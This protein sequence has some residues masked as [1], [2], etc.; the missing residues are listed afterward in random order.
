MLLLALLSVPAGL[1]RSLDDG[2]DLYGNARFGFFVCYPRA[3]LK[4]QGEP[5]NGDGNTFKS[6]DGRVTVVAYGNYEMEPENG[7]KPLE[8][9]YRL[10]LA[11]AQKD[12]Y[13]ITYQVLKPNLYAYSGIADAGTPRGRLRY[14]KTIKRGDRNA[15]LQ[16]D[17]PE[18]LRTT[19][20]PVVARMAG[21]LNLGHQVIE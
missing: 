8:A 7:V 10:M 21:C 1:A 20:D 6:K 18:S 3:L 11:G 13:R 9:S 19:I 2:W 16:A 12:G 15:T 4:P 17:Y 14:E 5:D